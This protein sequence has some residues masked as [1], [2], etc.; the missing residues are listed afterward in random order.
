MA[1]ARLASRRIPVAAL[2]AAL[3]ISEIGLALPSLADAAS[4][5]VVYHGS[6]AR[7]WIALTI[8]DGYNAANCRAIADILRSRNVPATYFPYA[9]A[10]AGAP[11]T[12]RRIAASFPIGNHT[13]THR[14]MTRLS[15]DAKLWELRRARQIVQNVTGR[16]M[17]PVF[18][19]PGGTYDTATLRA[20]G[21]LGF[22]YTVMWD[23][24]FAD[25]AT[26]SDAAHLRHA[27][28]GTNGSIIL[29]HCGPAS[30]VRILPRVIAGYR[31]RGLK[32]V[33]I[34]QMLGLTTTASPTPTPTPTPTPRP[35]PTPTPTT[36]PTAT[37][38]P[39]VA[40]TLEP[41]AEPTAPASVEPTT[42]PTSSAG[43]PIPVRS[44]ASPRAMK[45]GRAARSRRRSGGTTSR[46][47]V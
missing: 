13:V 16:P 15:W 40:P 4:S 8:D 34:P 45:P 28:R 47:S 36:V 30:S 46:R 38:T 33:T 5:I 37:P 1:Q 17:I 3:L 41:T 7:P 42:M 21:Y 23:T 18:R 2:A 32:F 22:R 11:T 31:A 27:M 44:A 10:V 20:A 6:R 19:P 24:T 14:T 39:T 26:M 43:E 35:T 9:R 29:L 25:T 12:W